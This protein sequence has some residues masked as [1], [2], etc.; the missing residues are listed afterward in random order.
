MTPIATAA[1]MRAIEAEAD[2][3]GHPYAVMMDLAGRAVA[4]EVM[5]LADERDIARPSVLVL[6]GP[7]NNGG[8]GLVAAAVLADAGMAVRVVTWRRA[9]DERVAEVRAHD[10]PILALDGPHDDAAN[11]ASSDLEGTAA[12]G[13][14]AGWLAE[15]DIVVDALLGTGARGPL[16]GAVADLL[17]R[18]AA[19]RPPLV[20]AVDLPTGLDADS[21]TLD[22][23]A[24]AADLTVTFGCA[25]PGHVSFPGAAAVGRLVMDGIGIPDDIIRAC[26]TP[27]L[28]IVTDADVAGWLPPRAPD[29]HK[30]TFGRTLVV[31]GSRAYPGAAALAAGGAYRAGCGLVTVAATAE[32]RAAVAAHLPEAT[33]LPLPEVHGGISAAAAEAVRTAWLAYDAVLIGPGLSR[34]R[35]VAEFVRVL[36]DGLSDLLEDAR[37]GR[38][39]VDADGLNL[40]ADHP[41]GPRALPIGAVLTPHPGEMARLTGLTVAAVNADRLAV[42]R[43]WAAAWRHVVVLKGAHTVVAA[44]DG[45][46][47]IVPIATAA[48]AKAGTGDVL[49]G[50]IAGLLAAGA[51]QFEA[52]AT[53]VHAHA[54]A[55]LRLAASPAGDRAA[56]AGDLLAHIGP[57]WRSLEDGSPIAPAH[58]MTTGAD[59]AP[60][61]SE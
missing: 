38:V 28:G 57:V 21:G 54:L 24:L 27:P 59:A 31:A 15:A 48:L 51:P 40:L 26:A 3:R 60:P 20:V 30:G 56:V 32:V 18:V 19:A 23:H 49:A 39:V 50:L 43:R 14:L 52:A 13:T 22:A 58:R 25:K 36:L 16:T 61:P 10:V 35:G 44:P 11:V 2:R 9:P 7:G 42:A 8:D 46:C 53:A 55:G 1:Q 33:Y 41:A 47:A 45:R 17:D 12:D 6:C 29:A 37:P 5:G 4:R 34:D